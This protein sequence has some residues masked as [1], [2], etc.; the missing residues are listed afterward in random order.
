MEKSKKPSRP[1]QNYELLQQQVLKAAENL[2]KNQSIA[3]DITNMVLLE[4]SMDES[5]QSEP[6]AKISTSLAK[7]SETYFSD[8]WLYCYQYALKLIKREELAQDI[9]QEAIASL[10][11]ADKQV[12]YIRGWLKRTVFNQAQI[13][14]KLIQRESSLDDPDFRELA[15]EEEPADENALQ[16]QLGSK[17]IRKYLSAEDYR[18]YRKIQ[19]YPNLKAYAKAAK[20]SY[21]TARE[22]RHMVLH[23]LKHNYLK[24]QGWSGTPQI[25]SFRHLGNVKRFLRTL[26]EHAEQKTMHKLSRYC[27]KDILEEVESTLQNLKEASD[28]GIT[29]L[30]SQNFQ[31]FVWGE[32]LEDVPNMYIINITINKGNSI[33]IKSCKEAELMGMIEESALDV[34][35]LEKG[36]CILSMEEIYRLIG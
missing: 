1:E 4:L 13:R 7:A 17:E 20:L 12:E 16:E 26:I 29:M 6:E 21:Q 2:Y 14:I 9:A 32:T 23:N 31:V 8:L 25:L 19:E 10:F 11:K 15:A 30:D 3:K 33:R 24:K 18:L 22:H 35:P 34:L 28:W 5:A 27:P 36:T